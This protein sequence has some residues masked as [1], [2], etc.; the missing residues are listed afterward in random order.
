MEI[1]L[2]RDPSRD[3]RPV[4]RQIAESILREIEGG[5]LEGGARLPPIRDLA[6]ELEVNRELRECFDGKEGVQAFLEKR[7][8]RFRGE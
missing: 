7:P 8:A 6:R 1:V 3:G 5:R 4:Y 2:E